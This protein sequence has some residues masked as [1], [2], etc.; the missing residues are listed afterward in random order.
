MDSSTVLKVADDYQILIEPGELFLIEVPCDASHC[1]AQFKHPNIART[2]SRTL[3]YRHYHAGGSKSWE[4]RDG[5]CHYFAVPRKEITL[6][7]EK[8]YS[9]VKAIINGAEVT[10]NVSGGTHGNGWGDFLHI[11]TSLCSNNPIATLKAI[12]E[13]SVRGSEFEPV[14]TPEEIE[15]AF[16]AEHG[17]DWLVTAAWGD[18]QAG[19]PKGMVGVCARVGGHRSADKTE[20]WFLVP[21]AEYNAGRFVIDLKRHEEV[22]DFTRVEA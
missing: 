5:I 13:V 2:V 6:I 9:Y 10:F 3:H 15:E 20:R 22:K 7:P 8:G 17:S 1:S 14:R 12:A 18:W 21:A 19:V 4:E 16:Y 11:H